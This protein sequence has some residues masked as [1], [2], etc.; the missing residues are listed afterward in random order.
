MVITVCLHC[1]PYEIYNPVSQRKLKQ[2]PALSSMTQLVSVRA[3]MIFGN[4]G[5]KPKAN[6]GYMIT[7]KHFHLSVFTV[8]E[9]STMTPP[10][11]QYSPA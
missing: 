9:P 1:T 3:T 4:G 5:K 10:P 6:Q 11:R 2:K 8:F 7:E